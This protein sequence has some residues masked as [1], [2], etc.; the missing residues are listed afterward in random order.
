MTFCDIVS[1]QRISHQKSEI[2]LQTRATK[3]FKSLFVHLFNEALMVQQL[4]EKFISKKSENG[5]S[6]SSYKKKLSSTYLFVLS[7]WYFHNNKNDNIHKNEVQNIGFGIP[8][9]FLSQRRK[10]II[11]IGPET[12]NLTFVVQTFIW[13]KYNIE[14]GI[15]I[16]IPS[17]RKKNY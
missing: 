6:D 13:G 17:Q 2:A 7:I 3:N 4:Q 5:P 11:V 12:T 1:D 14:F 10:K 8:I 15:P 9:E 16:K